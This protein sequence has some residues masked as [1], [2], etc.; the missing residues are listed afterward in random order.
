METSRSNE[1]ATRIVDAM[2]RCVAKYGASGAT[3]ENVAAEAGVSRGLL[4]Y[5]F[6]TK[7]NL[8]VEVVRRQ[9]DVLAEL[10]SEGRLTSTSAEDAVTALFRSVEEMVRHDPDLFLIAFEFIGVAR[11]QPEL[12]ASVADHNRKAY[13]EVAHGFGMFEK[14][15]GVTLR[16]GRGT[17]ASAIMAMANGLAF[18]ML[19]RPDDDHEGTIAALI[20]AALCLLTDD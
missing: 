14:S 9:A 20:D 10:M 18:E 2:C 8:L 5:Y 19:E 11:R 4:H 15:T 1:K 3:F 7:E 17:T 13:S 16:H 12:G 6:G